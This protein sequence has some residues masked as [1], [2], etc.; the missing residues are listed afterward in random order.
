MVNQALKEALFFKQMV[1]STLSQEFPDFI[2]V[3]E[4]LGLQDVDDIIP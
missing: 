3:R 1:V 4:A 2:A